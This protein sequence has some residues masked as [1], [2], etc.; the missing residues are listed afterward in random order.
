MPPEFAQCQGQVDMRLYEMR[1]MDNGLDISR[2]STGDIAQVIQRQGQ[3]EFGRHVIGLCRECLAI[4]TGG[5]GQTPCFAQQ[6]P[7]IKGRI[8][9]RWIQRQRLAKE[10]L[11]LGIV[12]L[13]TIR[14]A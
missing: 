4:G 8:G 10:F 9:E 6:V 5:L 1:R 11:G 7:E 13:Q 14:V 12:R 3:I 2:R